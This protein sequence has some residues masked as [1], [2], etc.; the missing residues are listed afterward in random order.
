MAKAGVLDSDDFS[1]SEKNFS[2]RLIKDFQILKIDDFSD[3]RE[4]RN[5]ANV[6]VAKDRRATI[7]KSSHYEYYY[8]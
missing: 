2:I 7:R 8:R 5:I 4:L 3:N 6:S 1:R